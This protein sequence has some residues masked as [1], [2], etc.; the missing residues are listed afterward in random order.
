M[1]PILFGALVAAQ[2]RSWCSG[3]FAGVIEAAFAA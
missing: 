1:T 3:I 2:A